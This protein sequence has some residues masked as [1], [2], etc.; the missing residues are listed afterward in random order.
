MLTRALGTLT[1]LTVC[2]ACSDDG[3]D[4]EPEDSGADVPDAAFVEIG[5]GFPSFVP[6]QDGQDLPIIQGIQGGFHLWGGF[7]ADGLATRGLTIEFDIDF[8]GESVGAATYVD[9]LVG[10]QTPFDYGGVA[11]I[12]FNNDLPEEVTGKPVTLSVTLTDTD[13]ITVSDSVEVVPQCCSF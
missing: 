6:V 9:D 7:R 2:A 11:V 13:G 5:T 12:F 10:E 8:D 3:P 1:A 4:P